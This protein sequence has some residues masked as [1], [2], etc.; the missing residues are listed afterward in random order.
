MYV[1]ES[2]RTFL[3]LRSKSSNKTSNTSDISDASNAN[4]ASNAGNARNARNKNRKMRKNEHLY[5]HAAIN[6]VST[7]AIVANNVIV[8]GEIGLSFLILE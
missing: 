8:E 5:I 2:E 7:R 6:E 1:S 4:Y 3:R